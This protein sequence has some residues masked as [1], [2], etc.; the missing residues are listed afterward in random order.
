MS[1]IT[2]LLNGNKWLTLGCG[3][4]LTFVV[5]VFS[6]TWLRKDPEADDDRAAQLAFSNRKKAA[7]EE[8]VAADG[9][10]SH[11]NFSK[12]LMDQTALLIDARAA[13]LHAAGHIWG[14]R[15]A[16]DMTSLLKWIK[17]QSKGKSV[18]IY[19]QDAQDLNAG[20][21]ADTLKSLGVTN[22]LIYREGIACWLNH[23]GPVVT[24]S[25]S[26]EKP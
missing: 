21:V 12:A 8:P 18:I 19:G 9:E 22:I 26:E 10:I 23:H 6:A 17:S 24:S 2:N 7:L 20:R 16:D 25:T 1:F 11:L 13:D 15:T 14:S 4:V 3:V 5:V